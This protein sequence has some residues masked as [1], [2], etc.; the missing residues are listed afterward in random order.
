MTAVTPA[1]PVAPAPE[2]VA[3]RAAV[4]RRTRKRRLARAGWNVLGLAVFAVMIFPVFW[5]LY[6]AFKPDD[7]IN[8]LTPTWF[9]ASPTLE[10]FRDAIDPALHPGFWSSVKNSLMI[11]GLTVVLSM[12]LAFLAAVAL[13]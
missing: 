1:A 10:N 2:T 8:S 9:S 13:A 3:P 11:V 12:V 7:E 4:A 6:T 5:M